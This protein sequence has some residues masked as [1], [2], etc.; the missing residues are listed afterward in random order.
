MKELKTLM[1]LIATNLV[2]KK[3]DPVKNQI[4]KFVHKNQNDELFE[5]NIIL[6][7]YFLSFIPL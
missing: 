4:N 2:N 6:L 3:Y 1:N 5:S 7:Q